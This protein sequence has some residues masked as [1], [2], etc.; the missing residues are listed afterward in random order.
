MSS[1]SPGWIDGVRGALLDVD[2][3]LW[4]AGRPIAGAP[5]ALDRLRAADVPF[6]L[7]TNTTRRPRSAIA[8]AL[9]AVGIRVAPFEI[10]VPATLAARRIAASGR[11]RVGL[12]VPP[13][14]AEDLHGLEV[15]DTSPDWV[16]VGD[17]GREFTFERLN[18]AFHW[19]RG[20]ARLLAL[21]RGRSWM[22]DEGKIDMDAGAFV[23]ALEYAASV[24]AELVGKPAAPF[25]ELALADLG[26][27]ASEV[28]VVGDDADND[29][30][31]GAAAGLRTALVRTGK[32]AEAGT[33]PPVPP[34]IE[35]DSVAALRP[36]GS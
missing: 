8:A 18:R 24:E 27:R 10:L 20:G 22:S 23:A 25:F 17:L 34:D 29:I 9:A 2:G 30:A 31:G 4:E 13:A 5:E 16:V 15:V 1:S 7:T 26:M 12:L 36:P 11:T 28:M 6:R 14:C 3:T 33:D 32:N 35:I 19:L 21:H